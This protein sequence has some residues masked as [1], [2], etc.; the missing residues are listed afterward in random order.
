M[1]LA[2]VKLFLLAGKT[3][4]QVQIH[5]GVNQMMIFRAPVDT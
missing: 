3:F 5:G 4:G 1:E 2:V